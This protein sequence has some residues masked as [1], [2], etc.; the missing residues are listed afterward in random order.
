MT[1]TLR[2]TPPLTEAEQE[3]L[4]GATATRRLRLG[5]RAS[6]LATTQ[7]GWVAD[8]L[9]ARGHQVDL[10]PVRTEGDES[11]ASLREIG[12]TGVFA[13]ALRT[14]L[15]EDRIDVAVHSLKD[16][17][18]APVPGLVLAAIPEREDPRDVVVARDGLTLAGLPEGA[19]VGTGSPRRAAQL[20]V[21]APHLQIRDIRG[22]IDSRVGQVRS[23]TLDAVVLAAAGLTRVG[24]ID[25]ATEVLP[26]VQMLP[27]PGQ[28]ALAVECR[29]DDEAVTA[30]CAELDDPDTRACVEA[31]RALLARLEAGC[32]A[33]VGAVARLGGAAG[34]DSGGDPRGAMTLTGFADLQ[35]RA[36]RHEV[37][38]TDPVSLGHQLADLF[39]ADRASTGTPDP[40]GAPTAGADHAGNHTTERDT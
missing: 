10:V 7:A 15:L 32:T 3:C 21:F 8:L 25:E 22:N 39:L 30:W 40:A 33:P 19:V 14:A 6:E 27:A 24:R 9:R 18:V 31:E 23:G 5:T 28:G 34:P 37:S 16:L 4:P 1:P 13:S 38:G 26:F 12:G 2:H 20:A 29:D 36:T 35:G 17:P 11:T